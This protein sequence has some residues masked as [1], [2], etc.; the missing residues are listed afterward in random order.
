MYLINLWNNE[1]VAMKKSERIV[2]EIKY[3]F[4]SLVYAYVDVS[5]APSSIQIT[6]FRLN[7]FGICL[8]FLSIG[9]II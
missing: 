1:I 3:H 6:Y 9:K 5:V 7:V 2:A 4:S 8:F